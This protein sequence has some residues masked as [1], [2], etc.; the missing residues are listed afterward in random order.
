ML[1]I[2]VSGGIGYLSGEV[3]IRRWNHDDGWIV[4]LQSCRGGPMTDQEISKKG[5]SQWCTRHFDVAVTYLTGEQRGSQK[6]IL[7]EQLE[8]SSLA[9]Y[10]NRRYVLLVDRFPDG[11]VQYSVSDRFRLP[12]VVAFLCGTAGLVCLFAGW[13]G[14]RAVV[15]LGLSLLV[16]LKGFVPAVLA[17]FSPVPVALLAVALVSVVTVCLV[18]RRRRYR[19]VAFFGAL[20]GTGAACLLGW[21]AVEL[22]QITGLGSEGGALFASTFPGY[23]MRGIFLASVIVGAIGAVLDVAISVTSAMAE[24]VDHAPSI[25]PSRLWA[26]GLAVGREILG[27]MINTLI[28]AYFGSSLIMVLLIVTSGLSIQFIL[29]DPMV[30][31]ELIQSLAGTL[32]LLLTVPLTASVGVWLVQKKSGVRR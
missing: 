8:G 16:L 26:S 20:G 5:D 7:V 27:S 23:D 17:G 14:V 24:L 1:V 29:N 31:Q 10:P 22:W 2:M 25:E 9:L 18:V 12:W 3:V 28:L 30:S 19:V 6:S 21:G 15:G 11:T 32:G 4:E 13:T